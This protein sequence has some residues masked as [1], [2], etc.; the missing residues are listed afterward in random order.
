MTAHAR[1]KHLT[2]LTKV[3]EM[4]IITKSR[5]LHERTHR[6]KSRPVEKEYLPHSCLKISRDYNIFLLFFSSFDLFVLFINN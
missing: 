6:Q 4:F 2:K 3:A 5:N 1:R